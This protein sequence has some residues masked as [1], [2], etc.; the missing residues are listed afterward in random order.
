MATA[1]GGGTSKEY[2]FAVQAPGGTM[3]VLQ[4]YGSSNTFPYTPTA[5]GTYN[6]RV[7]ARNV[8]SAAVYEAAQWCIDNVVTSSPVTSVALAASPLSP[9][10]VNTPVTFMATA[11]GGGTSKEYQFAV[12]APGGTMTVLQ[13]YGSSN[14]FPYTPTAAGTYNIRVYA[15]NVGS[16]ASY[17]A[18]WW[19]TDNVVTSSPVISVTLAA[20]PVSPRLVNTPVNFTATATG[21][22]ASKEYQFAV[23]DPVSGVMTVIQQY[24]PSNTF[25]Y[26]P[27]AAGT[28]T[29]RVYARNVG[30]A[31]S[32]EAGWWF[33]DNVVT[34]SPVISVTLAAS[35]VSPRLVNTPVNFTATATGG[36]A[37]K[38]Y[39]FAVKDPVS[40]VMTVIQQYG[41]SNTFPYTPTAAGTYTI[42]VYA[43]NVGSAA[44]YE[45]G[46]WFTDNVVTS[47]PVISVTLAASPVSPRLVNTPVNFTATATGGGTSKEYQFAVKD[48]VSGVMTVL[49]QYGPSNTFPYT[50]TAAGTYTIRAPSVTAGESYE[51]PGSII[52]A[53]QQGLLIATGRN[54]LLIKEIQIEGGKRL[55]LQ[56]FLRGRELAV[57]TILGS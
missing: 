30:S 47:S 6:I 19:F 4:P 24:G 9:R 17:E 14:T 22:G 25:P 55:D 38:E 41:P 56:A 27:T 57:G 50:P 35:P 13:P 26:T 28:Y 49:Q 37:S 48:P 15:R 12:Q 32:Y 16:A 5:A 42:R 8:G 11:T 53:D 36:G 10:L 43:R 33:T 7:Y 1:T 21:G 52:R 2:Q 44:S 40:G 3:T 54:R 46:W 23:K 34:S 31:A 20:S 45:A 18:G 51:T 39:Q 29:I